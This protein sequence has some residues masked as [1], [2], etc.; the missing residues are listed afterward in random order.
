LDNKLNLDIPAGT[1]AKNRADATLYSIQVKTLAESPEVPQS[2]EAVGLVYELLPDGA[3]F[4]PPIPLTIEYD[5]SEIPEGMSESNLFI[6]K[7]IES[8][9]K[10]IELES[11]V[12]PATQTVT[13]TID[14][15]S[16]H[17]IMARFQPASFSLTDL[18][19]NPESVVL[20]GDIS[21]SVL[22]ENTG[23]LT[24]SYE[25]NLKINDVQAQSQEITLGGGDSQQ[26]NF[27]VSPETAG[28]YTVN[29]GDLTGQCEVIAPTP[30]A[31]Q[32]L[33][34]TPA[35]ASFAI[36]DLSV[37]PGKVRPAEQVTISALVAN[38]GGS[39]GSYTV[40]LNIN[41]AE[42]ARQEV[43]L[44]VD[45]SELATFTVARDAEGRYTV[46]ID[47]E[48]G[49]F[50][51]IIPPL[52]MPAPTEALPVTPPTNWGL[53]GGIIAGCLIVVG[54]LLVY[55]FVWRKRSTPRPS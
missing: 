39:E 32:A 36:S 19:I 37:T 8:S 21:V 50:T 40:I 11:T 41:G 5:I 25:V 54:G 1:F 26:V 38:T 6:A 16:I 48:T 27:N 7:W 24:G 2:M 12:D 49:Q 20:G 14:G 3:K 35:P 51:V 31:I 9:E 52:L 28:V 18:T 46:D 42:E 23:D 33:P 55:F 29:I 43:T 17:T 47:G 13:T 22:L 30:A 34:P 15:F 44:G 4:D 53:I 10:W 45:R